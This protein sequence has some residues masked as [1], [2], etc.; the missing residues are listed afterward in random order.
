MTISF[1]SNK[2]IMAVRRQLLE[3][4]A[5]SIQCH[6]LLDALPRLSHNERQR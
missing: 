6:T 2:T 5:G 1:P 3:A 4:M